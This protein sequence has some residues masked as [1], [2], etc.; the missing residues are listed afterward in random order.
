MIESKDF[1]HVFDRTRLELDLTTSQTQ[2]GTVDVANPTNNIVTKVQVEI[3]QFSECTMGQVW[4]TLCI[5]GP[6]FYERTV[7][8]NIPL[9]FPSYFVKKP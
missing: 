7:S 3:S 9:P 5:Q 6:S 8:R 2:S 1:N 4:M